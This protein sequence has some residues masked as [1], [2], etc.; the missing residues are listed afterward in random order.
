M[1]TRARKPGD[2]A[3]AVPIDKLSVVLVALFGV[4]SPGEEPSGL[5][6]LGVAMIA[7]GRSSWPTAL[8]AARARQGLGQLLSGRGSG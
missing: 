5:N 7:A 2:A 8:S 4:A 3:C 6:R 1:A